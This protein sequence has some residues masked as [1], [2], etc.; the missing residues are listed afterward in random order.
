MLDSAATIYIL[1]RE[2]R[3]DPAAMVDM[4]AGVP[5]V[6]HAQIWLVVRVETID[7]GPDIMTQI[8]ADLTRWSDA[9][10]NVTG[11]QI[12]FDASTRGLAGYAVFLRN[13]RRDLDPRYRLSV[14]G[15]LDWSSNGDPDAL[16]AL[17]GTVDEIVLQTYQGRETIPGYERY[18]ARLNRMTTPFRIGLVQ[19]GEW[20][21]PAGLRDQPMYRG[22]VVFLV[23]P[24]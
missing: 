23:N 13:V 19:G 14:T 9:G 1:G 22:T 2:V 18:L 10:N 21:E 16:A 24:R 4:R 5:H 3:G 12:D 8:A 6:D 20:R 17:G 11:V 15:L 7:W